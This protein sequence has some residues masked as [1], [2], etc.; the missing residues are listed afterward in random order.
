MDKASCLMSFDSSIDHQYKDHT[1]AGVDE[2]GRGA[3]AGPVV[4][5]AVIIKRAEPFNME[6]TDSKKLSIQKRQELSAKILSTHYC[7]IGLAS[8]EEIN[9]LGLNPAL[10]LAMERALNSLRIRPSLALIDGNYKVDFPPMETISIIKGDQKSISIAA[11]SI[12]AKVYRD[13]LMK[14]LALQHPQYLWEKNVGYGTAHH[15][16]MLKKYGTSPLHRVNFKP[17]KCL[18]AS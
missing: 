13:S 10:F 1:L 7:G 15:I 17:I 4:A 18:A 6:I 8:V 11:A 2:V 14:E 5:G 12:I 16:E 3:W 9:I